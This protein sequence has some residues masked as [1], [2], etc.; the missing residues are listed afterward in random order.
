MAAPPPDNPSGGTRSPRWAGTRLR[1]VELLQV[2]TPAH[3][4]QLD[5]FAGAL[6]AEL[7][8]AYQVPN[9]DPRDGGTRATALFLLE[10]PGPKA[11]TSGL[12]SQD[13]PDP[14]ARNMTQ[15]LKASGFQRK[16]VVLWNVVP[17]YVGTG[18]KIRPVTRA[19]LRAALPHLQRLLTLLPALR[20]IVLVGRKAQAV[21]A[22]IQAMTNVPLVDSYHP[23]NLVLNR[24]PSRYGEILASF[25]TAW[26]IAMR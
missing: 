12:V 21:R 3:L 19:D 22:D 9:F 18:D 1:E 25:E 16:D 24:A 2:T 7:G 23:S 17:W 14:S 15:L 6:R 26:Q 13:N 10:A 11:V 4:L 5:A 20:V 8:T